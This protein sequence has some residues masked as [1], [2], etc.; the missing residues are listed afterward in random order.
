MFASKGLV[1]GHTRRTFFKIRNLKILI[2]LGF[3]EFF[4]GDSRDTSS[5]CAPDTSKTV[6]QPS[7][8]HLD[9]RRH[10][11]GNKHFFSLA[12]VN[13]ELFTMLGGALGSRHLSSIRQEPPGGNNINV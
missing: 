10:E 4:V 12:N 5:A 11:I 9:C 6:S 2:L 3:V 13:Y 7:R 8:R 1:N